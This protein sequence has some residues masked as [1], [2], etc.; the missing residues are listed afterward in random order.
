MHTKYL[1]LTEDIIRTKD[2]ETNY[3]LKFRIF[4]L[5]Q[6]DGLWRSRFNFELYQQVKEPSI[7][8]FARILRLRWAAQ[9]A[10]MEERSQPK[11]V[12][13]LGFEGRIPAGR[14]RK[15]WQDEVVGHARRIDESC[16]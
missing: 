11:R 14:T 10:S 9:G 16:N 2:Q 4:G 8:E 7:S 13:E 12:L 15:R 5:K 6:E 1:P 3:C